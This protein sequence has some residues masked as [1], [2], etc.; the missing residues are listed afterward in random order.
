MNIEQTRELVEWVLDLPP[1]DRRECNLSLLGAPPLVDLELA[2]ACNITCRFCPRTEMA[3]NS[4][5]MSEE[6]FAAV[7][8]L[9]P[10]DAVVMLSGLGE[11]LLQP[12]LPEWVARLTTSGRSTC[13]ITNGVRLTP[14]RQDDLIAAGIA[15]IQVSVHSL[16]LETARKVVPRGARPD[17]VRGHL[18]R[19]AAVRPE[20]LGV[21]LNFVE[22]PDNEPDLAEVEALAAR[23]GFEFFYRREHSRGGHYGTSR[24]AN[25]NA[26]CGIFA[27]VT[28]ITADGDVLP[29][30][31]DVRGDGVLGNV[32][33]L[34][35]GEVVRWKARVIDKDECFSACSTCDDDYRWILIGQGALDEPATS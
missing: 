15:Q 2:S 35:W 13:V 16:D 25:A 32:R 27:A 14:T 29:C 28:F 17:L 34:T 24:A 23:L 30:V 6:T 10:P 20:T 22:T 18:E 26:G 9:L 7:M 1:E 8:Q 12:R 31:N 33:A 5:L 21:R 3:R 4:A 19:L 11:A